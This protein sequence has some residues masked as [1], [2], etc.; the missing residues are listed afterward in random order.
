MLACA[1]RSRSAPILYL[2]LECPRSA[3]SF[4]TVA[5]ATAFSVW[6]GFP[7]LFFLCEPPLDLG[8][9]SAI[10]RPRF[11]D[12]AAVIAPEVQR[13]GFS[14]QGSSIHRDFAL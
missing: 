1:S 9:L 8:R 10:D 3:C 14:V 5:V 11:L 13:E 7:H 2:M 12:R 4:A 6:D